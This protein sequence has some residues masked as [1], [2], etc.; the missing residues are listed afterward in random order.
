[1]SYQ[2]YQCIRCGEWEEIPEGAEVAGPDI[3]LDCAVPPAAGVKV[4][5]DGE[6]VAYRRYMAA[7]RRAQLARDGKRIVAVMLVETLLERPSYHGEWEL[8]RFQH[9]AEEEGKALAERETAW[10]EYQTIVGGN[11]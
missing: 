1:M 2:E 3:C 9:Y 11:A 10:L 6:E 7:E 4:D 8:T 5:L